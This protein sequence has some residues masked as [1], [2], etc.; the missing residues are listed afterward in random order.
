M[1]RQRVT[2]AMPL[3]VVLMADVMSLVL[4]LGPNLALW[5]FVM[6]ALRHYWDSPLFPVALII[7][8]L[9]APFVFIGT[10]FALRLC[11]PRLR[12]G[13]YKMSLNLG[14]IAWYAN[15]AVARASRVSGLDL[16][17]NAFYVL[18]WLHWRALGCK[19]AFNVNSSLVV[20]MVDFPL[21]T[22]KRGCTIA[23]EVVIG[24]HSFTGGILMLKPTVIGENVFV[25]FQSEVLGTTI[26]DGAWIGRNNTLMR[27]KVPPGAVI[28]NYEMVH[29]NPRKARAKDQPP[30]PA[31]APR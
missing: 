22:I 23:D 14:L 11:V 9:L 4:T 25:G 17:F 29:G 8:P 28:D 30:P 16:L 1:S 10:L 19:I 20:Q 3:P 21:I 18:K 27:E 31:E 7:V 15:N 5:A 26:G 12:P 13:V 2:T 6:T 24:C